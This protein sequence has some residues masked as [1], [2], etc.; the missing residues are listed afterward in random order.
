MSKINTLSSRFINRFNQQELSEI[1]LKKVLEIKPD[2]V[3]SFIMF[4]LCADNSCYAQISGYPLIYSAWGNDLYYLQHKTKYLEEITNSLGRVNYMFA[5][6]DRDF[7]IAQ[8]H[9]FRGEYLGTF[10]T[11]GGYKTAYYDSFL[12]SNQQRNII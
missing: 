2:V 3:H 10:P 8:G 6:C 5:D 12:S 7:K 9:G 11:G 4:C 1:F